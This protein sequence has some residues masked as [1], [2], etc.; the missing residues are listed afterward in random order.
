[1]SWLLLEHIFLRYGSS[2]IQQLQS[3]VSASM[4]CHRHC[5]QCRF[6]ELKRN[7][8]RLAATRRCMS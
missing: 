6:R 4:G 1:M 8:R 5:P 7:I 2:S 3:P